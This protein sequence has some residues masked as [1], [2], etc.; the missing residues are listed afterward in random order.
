MYS[1]KL[2]LGLFNL[3]FTC[4]IFGLICLVYI[5]WYVGGVQ[6]KL[7]IDVSFTSAINAGYLAT[8]KA[9]FD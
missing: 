9:T 5:A 6:S 4:F 3:S 8:L 2:L 1:Y 7:A